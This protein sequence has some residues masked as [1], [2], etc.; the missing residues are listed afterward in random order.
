[1]KN[2]TYTIVGQGLAGSMLA[3]FLIKNKQKITI[4]NNP[5]LASSSNIA[6]GIFNPVTGRRMVETWMAD[7][8]FPF[9]ENTY[10]DLETE[11][12]E[13]GITNKFFF[14]YPL[15][16]PFPDEKLKNILVNKF[17]EN[18]SKYVDVIESNEYNFIKKK[19][20]GL[21]INHTGWIDIKQLIINFNLYF[22]LLKIPILET[23]KYKYTEFDSQKNDDNITLYCEGFY[24]T[25]NPYFSWLPFKPVKG[26]ILTIQLDSDVK[27]FNHIIN[28][29]FFVLPIANQ[30]FKLGATYDWNNLNW[31]TTQEASQVLLEKLQKV[32]SLSPIKTTQQAGIRPATSDRR[33]FI[34]MHPKYP[35]HG[36][37]NGFGSKGASLIPYFANEFAENLIFDKELNLEVNITRFHSLYLGDI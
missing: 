5:T 33:P 20:G 26:E 8:I 13:K 32:T 14:P 28:Q 31:D 3:Y 23:E 36:I 6:A 1:M 7:E 35:Q 25:Q 27:P 24:G 17:Q 4:V 30:E 34:G 15:F 22:K 2:K 10:R 37:F 29:G 11:F 16:Y 18:H 21:S 19:M 12:S 9:L